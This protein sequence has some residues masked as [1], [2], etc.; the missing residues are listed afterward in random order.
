MGQ[1]ISADTERQSEM[2]V[3]VGDWMSPVATTIGPYEL[4]LVA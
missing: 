1:R 3:H 4:R 2:G